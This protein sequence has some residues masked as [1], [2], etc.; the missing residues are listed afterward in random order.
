MIFL[1]GSCWWYVFWGFDFGELLRD[2]DGDHIPA[3]WGASYADPG[4]GLFGDLRMGRSYYV[5]ENIFSFFGVNL[6][7]MFG[8]LRWYRWWWGVRMGVCFVFFCG[9]G[10]EDD[11]WGNWDRNRVGLG[12]ELLQ[13]GGSWP[14]YGCWTR[15]PPP[16]LERIS[17]LPGLLGGCSRAVMAS[18]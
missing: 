18:W 4:F 17:W 16:L 2:R 1:F 12:T 3:T 13:L 8:W 9:L 6:G 7:M 5:G 10:G 15:G 14:A 11:E